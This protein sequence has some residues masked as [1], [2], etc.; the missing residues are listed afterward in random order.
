MGSTRGPRPCPVRAP[1]YSPHPRQRRVLLRA[2]LLGGTPSPYY[3]F[4][5]IDAFLYQI[6][7][8]DKP[9]PELHYSAQVIWAVISGTRP[10]RASSTREFPDRLWGI[11][12][13]CWRY[14]PGDRPGAV[15]LKHQL[16]S[17]TRAESRAGARS[18]LPQRAATNMTMRRRVCASPG[19][20]SSWPET[21]CHRSATRRGTRR[22]VLSATPS[23]W[24]SLTPQQPHG[25]RPYRM[26]TSPAVL[27]TT[28]SKPSV[29]GLA[30]VF[31]GADRLVPQRIYRPPVLSE[32]ASACQLVMF[33]VEGPQGCGVSCEDAIEGCVD[34]LK[35]GDEPVKCPPS[36]KLHI[37]VRPI[38]SLV[39]ST[40]VLNW[41]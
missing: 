37:L 25:P 29:R 1:A 23:P 24:R 28:E 13:D 27:V 10:A 17:L 15:A 8:D 22:H 34:G 5:F 40:Q 12:E 38:I 36:V 14:N 31:P 19:V 35:G 33:D 30:S 7:N 39:F 4:Q 16:R 20:E 11:M 41:E 2:R 9:F 6:Y 18:P 26:H 21:D 3:P 32:R